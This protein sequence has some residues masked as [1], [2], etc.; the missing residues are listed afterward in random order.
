MP[1]CFMGF[2]LSTSVGKMLYRP[3]N[4]SFA[5]CHRAFLGLTLPMRI[6]DAYSS[7]N[8]SSAQRCCAFVGLIPSVCV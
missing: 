2:I 7:P 6:G 3:Q 1:L 5:Q 8:V 4:V